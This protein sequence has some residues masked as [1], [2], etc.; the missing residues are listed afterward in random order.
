MMTQWTVAK[1][2]TVIKQFLNSKVLW[3]CV[4]LESSNI[5][6]GGTHGLKPSFAYGLE[7]STGFGAT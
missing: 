1:P 5:F 3:M 7:N 6:S 4:V 2:R